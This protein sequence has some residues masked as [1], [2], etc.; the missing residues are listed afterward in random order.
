MGPALHQMY[1]LLSISASSCAPSANLYTEILCLLADPLVLMTRF[2]ISKSLHGLAAVEPQ[3]TE[4]DLLLT[5][6]YICKFKVYVNGPSVLRFT[7]RLQGLLVAF[8]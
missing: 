2:W 3:I 6:Y 7:L 1:L 8:S 5:C 4:V